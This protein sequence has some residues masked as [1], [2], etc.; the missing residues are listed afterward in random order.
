MKRLTWVARMAR[1]P[2]PATTTSVDRLP[3]AVRLDGLT[4]LD[5]RTILTRASSMARLTGEDRHEGMYR[6]T[7]MATHTRL[8]RMVSPTSWNMYIRG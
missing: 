8:T 7:G 3:R 2:I 5:R 4:V 1:I 6:L